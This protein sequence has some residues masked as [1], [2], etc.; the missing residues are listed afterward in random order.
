KQVTEVHELYGQWEIILKIETAE[1][2]DLQDFINNV[3]RADKDI[4][5]TE[6]LIVSDVF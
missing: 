4:Q 1:M 3:I 5:G 6:T 2:A